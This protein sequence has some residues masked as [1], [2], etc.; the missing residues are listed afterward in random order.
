MV[1]ATGRRRDGSEGE[2]EG[3]DRGVALRENVTAFCR[4]RRDVG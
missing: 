2:S 4:G 3:N 1:M